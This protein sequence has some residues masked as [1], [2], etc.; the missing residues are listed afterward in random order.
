MNL[1]FS[2]LSNQ[3]SQ[4]ILAF[5]GYGQ[6]ANVFK[7]LAEKIKS[8]YNILVIDLPYQDVTKPIDKNQ[9]KLF[10]EDIMNTYKI[11]EVNGISY[12]MGSR[13]NLLLGECLPDKLKT[14]ILM[15]PDGIKIRAWNRFASSTMIG[16]WIYRYLVKS[17]N[18]Y[19]NFITILYKIKL[20]PKSM[21]AF[22]KWHMR[23]ISSRKKVYN[24]W[25]NMKKLIPNIK[26]IHKQKISHPFEMIA[27]F[28]KYDHIIK[29]AS[30]KKLAK[31]IPSCKIVLL[32]KGHNLL[33]KEL[34]DDISLHL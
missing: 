23:D 18:A 33:D 17:E 31:K 15:A 5:Y 9:F 11:K 6:D 28:G 21:Y 3:A 13:F 32:N 14:M 19:L 30:M 34:F 27:Y 12:S 10:I 16:N 20:M 2:I 7:P 8:K 25:L 26:T 4:W 1:S 24:S 29:E 22:S